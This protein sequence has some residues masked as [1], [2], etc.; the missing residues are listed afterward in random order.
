MEHGIIVNKKK[1]CSVLLKMQIYCERQMDNA[2]SCKCV[3]SDLYDFL[4][5]FGLCCYCHLTSVM[6]GTI[7]ILLHA[8]GKWTI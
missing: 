1:L 3:Y 8:Y 4:K 6:H 2:K 5:L 7:V